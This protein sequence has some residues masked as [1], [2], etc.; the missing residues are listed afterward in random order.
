MYVRGNFMN[1]CGGY[2]G[3]Q[4]LHDERWICCHASKSRLGKQSLGNI[5]AKYPVFR[6]MP[7]PKFGGDRQ[8]V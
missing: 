1:V 6:E 2:S 5:S 8:D 3:G 7:P 4:A